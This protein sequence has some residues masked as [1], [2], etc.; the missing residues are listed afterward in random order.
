VLDAEVTATQHQLGFLTLTLGV[1]PAS[2][3][4]AKTPRKFNGTAVGDCFSQW[5]VSIHSGTFATQRLCVRF[6][7]CSQF[8]LL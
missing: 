6:L 7:A 5:N 1:E 2:R 8:E 4:G 3:K